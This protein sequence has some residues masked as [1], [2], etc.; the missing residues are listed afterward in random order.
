MEW[1]FISCSVFTAEYSAIVKALE[2]V[3]NNFLKDAIIL[4]TLSGPMFTEDYKQC[5]KYIQL[6][7]QKRS[8]WL[9]GYKSN[10]F[11]IVFSYTNHYLNKSIETIVKTNVY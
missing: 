10:C 3:E 9:N 7:N 6:R 1:L 11:Y 5:K 2:L 4:T 8:R